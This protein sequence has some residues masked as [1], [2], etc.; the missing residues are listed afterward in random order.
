MLLENNEIIKVIGGMITE[1]IAFGKMQHPTGDHKH[2]AMNRL[3]LWLTDI[4]LRD[5]SFS[6]QTVIKI[7]HH[8]IP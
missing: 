3:T 8:Y 7:S 4:S 2:M 6:D 5:I 1:A